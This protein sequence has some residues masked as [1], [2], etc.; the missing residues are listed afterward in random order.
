[1]PPSNGITRI[2]LNADETGRTATFSVGVIEQGR[3]R[4]LVR[5]VALDYDLVFEPDAGNECRKAH[6]AITSD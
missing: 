5:L 3:P 4:A 2:S 1:M 6:L